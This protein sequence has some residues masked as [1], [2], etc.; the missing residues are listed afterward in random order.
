MFKVGDTVIVAFAVDWVF[1]PHITV[2]KDIV[3]K[4][5]KINYVVDCFESSTAN[6]SSFEHYDSRR[7]ENEIF[8]ATKDGMAAC[9]KYIL[10]YYYGGLCRGCKYDK[11]AGTVYRC[12]DCSHCKDTGKKNPADTRPM[13]CFL[14][15][16]TVGEFY[17]RS[18]SMEICRYFDPIFPQEKEVYKNWEYYDEILRNCE[19]NKECPHHKNSVHKTCTYEHYMDFELVSV[20]IHFTYNGREVTSIKIPRRRWVN[21]D[22]LNDDILECSVIYFSYERNRRGLPKK[23]CQP[24]FQSFEGMAKIDIKKGILIYGKPIKTL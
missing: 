8:E 9:K 4:N 14:N 2:V 22:F 24:I 23:E 13:K 12:R 10:D 15:N 5:G 16:I 17:T 21:Q 6:D 3:E 7:E 20:P 11:D 19:F 1:E 18:H